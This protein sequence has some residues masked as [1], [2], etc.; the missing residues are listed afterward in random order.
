MI[1]GKLLSTL[2][3]F[4]VSLNA[5]DPVKAQIEQ[6]NPNSNSLPNQT[7]NSS[8]QIDI[9]LETQNNQTFSEL[10]QQA[11]IQATSLIEQEFATNPTITEIAVNILGERQGQQVP[12]LFSR[13]SRARWQQQPIIRQWTKYFGTSAVLLGF[14]KPE[15]TPSLQNQSTPSTLRTQNVLRATPN[16]SVPPTPTSP[17]NAPV[18]GGASLEETEPGYR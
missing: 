11:E 6:I 1:Y 14:N 4:L 8:R 7:A 2:I 10:I 9:T 16:N 13:V 12:I 15:K 17:N 18:A 3:I 5:T